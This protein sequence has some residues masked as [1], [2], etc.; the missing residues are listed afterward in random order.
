MEPKLGNKIYMFAGKPGKI[1]G[2]RHDRITGLC[3]LIT[4]DD[5]RIKTNPYGV[6][7]KDLYFDNRRGAWDL[8]DDE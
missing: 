3:V 4:Y 1:T 6:P 7:V 8:I 5:I 2:F